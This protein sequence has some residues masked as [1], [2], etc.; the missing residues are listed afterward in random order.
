MAE[1]TQLE[2]KVAEVL[3]LAQAARESTQ[4]VK[5]LAQKEKKRELVQTL[6]QMAQEAA[7]TAKRV[8]QLTRSFEGKRTAIAEK[9]RETKEKAAK[10]RDTY[11]DDDADA[12]DGFEFLTMAEAGEVGHW[13]VVEKL[14]QEAKHRELREV[15]RW[16]KPIQRRH[17]QQAIDGSVRLAQEE[18][19]NEPA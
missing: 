17:F 4:K 2:A 9:A 1:L 12:L 7:E 14:N 13:T 6:N 3:G 11:L 5:Q 10:I 15:V 16:V 18:D 8:Q 19:P